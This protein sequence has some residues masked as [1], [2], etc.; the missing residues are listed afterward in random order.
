MTKPI[1][2]SAYEVIT[3]IDPETGDT[4]IPIPTELLERMEWKE[5]DILDINQTTDGRL[6]L[7]KVSK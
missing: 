2:S 3:Q 5:G 4:I 7:T 1:D 6:F